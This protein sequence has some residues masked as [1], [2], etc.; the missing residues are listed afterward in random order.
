MSG[1]TGLKV[2][3][4]G[5]GGLPMGYRMT[6]PSPVDPASAHDDMKLFV[7]GN[8]EEDQGRARHGMTQFN[9]F[10]PDFDRALLKAK[11]VSA[12]MP[13]LYEGG[14]QRLHHLRSDRGR[15]YCQLVTMIVLDVDEATCAR[16]SMFLKPCT[17][18]WINF[19][20]RSDRAVL[21]IEECGATVE[22]FSSREEAYQRVRSLVG[23]PERDDDGSFASWR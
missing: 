6:A 12:N 2:I 21:A 5:V 4:G 15:A 14:F 16:Q 11:S 20:T 19:R 23:A 9:R 1:Y 22:R 3:E 17:S 18:Q 13:V 7:L 8:Y 10:R